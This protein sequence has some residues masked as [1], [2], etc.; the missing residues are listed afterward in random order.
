VTFRPGASLDPSQVEDV[1]GNR[2]GGRGVAIGG[3]GAIG[4]VILIAYVLLGGSPNDLGALSGQVIG[5]GSGVGPAST[6]L[7][8]DCRTGADANARED[9]RI[10]GYVNSVQAYWTDEFA[11]SGSQYEPARTRFFTDQ[12]D[13]GCGLAS[14]ASGPF[15]CPADR[16]VYIDLGFFDDL[17][18]KFGASGGPAAQAYVLAHEYGHHVQDLLGVLSGAS[19]ATGATSR[20]VRTEL[21]ADCYAGVWATRAAA[22]GF[23]DPLTDAQIADA[24]D[25]AAAVG[26]DRI[27]AET[28]GSVSPDS[29]THGS[30]AQREKWFTSGYRSGDP[31]ACDTFSGTL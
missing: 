6:Q 5:D 21:Q 20:S 13:T 2:V 22:T 8:I 15:Y 16:Y 10:V 29:W 12:I 17:R 31:G 7:A 11:A 3:S 18:T 27:Q 25:A 9:C 1:R 14:A 23:L 26:D 24:L 4:L 28:Q 19:G 30:S